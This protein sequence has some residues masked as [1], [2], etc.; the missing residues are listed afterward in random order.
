MVWRL[1]LQPFC[2]EYT[3][4][5]ENKEQK[6]CRESRIYAHNDIDGTMAWVLSFLC[7]VWSLSRLDSGTYG[8]LYKIKDIPKVQ[9]EQ[10]L[11]YSQP[12]GL[13]SRYS[14]WNADFFRIF[15]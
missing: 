1:Y 11:R 6:S 9:K 10:I 4:L 7:P 14:I 3:S 8:Y 15:I 13:L 5:K 2:F 12:S